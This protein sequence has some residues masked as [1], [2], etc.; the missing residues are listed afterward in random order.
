MNRYL[1]SLVLH[2]N[3]IKC[4]VDTGF[5][6]FALRYNPTLIQKIVSIED[7]KNSFQEAIRFL[8]FSEESS[9]TIRKYPQKF[10]WPLLFEFFKG[11][12]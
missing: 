9:I 4:P 3:D 8:G 10:L 5:M 11:K 12:T 2:I 7:Y 6:L 1:K